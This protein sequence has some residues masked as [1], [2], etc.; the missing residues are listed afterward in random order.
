MLFYCVCCVGNDLG[1]ELITR[2]VESY[3]ACVFL[4]V[5]D[6]EKPTV[7]RPDYD[8]D[9]CVTERKSEFIYKTVTRCYVGVMFTD[10]LMFNE[11]KY[12]NSPHL[13]ENFFA[14]NFTL[15]G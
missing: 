2:S 11:V 5:C 13:I 8:L 10:L 3:R 1:D 7:R 6:L 4:I 15:S 12:P 14:N 9:C